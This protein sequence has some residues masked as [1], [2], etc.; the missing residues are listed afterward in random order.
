MSKSLITHVGVA[1]VWMFLSGVPSLANLIV[2]LVLTF[3]LLG[4]FRKA[5]HCESYVR[6]TLA[7]SSFVLHLFWEI[8]ISNLRIMRIVLRRDAGR[9]EGAFVEYDVA[10]LD[11]FE[12]LLLA[13]CV[14]LSPGTISVERVAAGKLVLHVYPSATVE[15]VQE[16]IDRTLKNG[17]LSFTR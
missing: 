16:Y 12:V 14:G 8:I 1:L 11:E 7:F 3:V 13:G 9:I 4:I 15:A 10:G 6:R 2:A 17:I 5:L